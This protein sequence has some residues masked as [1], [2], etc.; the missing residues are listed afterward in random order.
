MLEF[1]EKGKL[2]TMLFCGR[3]SKYTGEGWVGKFDCEK[4]TSTF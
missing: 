2:S 3:K 1:D 4:K